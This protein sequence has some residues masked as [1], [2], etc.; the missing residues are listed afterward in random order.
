MLAVVEARPVTSPNATSVGV[1][2]VAG[3]ELCLFAGT[4]CLRVPLEDT[5]TIEPPT[6]NATLAETMTSVGTAFVIGRCNQVGFD[7]TRATIP[8]GNAK[9]AR[10]MR[11]PPKPLLA[12]V[13]RAHR[14]AAL[15][16]IQ[17]DVDGV[18]LGFGTGAPGE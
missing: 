9:S 18:H 7:V 15:P 10:T 3:I 4:A 17:V 5:P 6:S 13:M 12:A 14:I 8:V 1:G 11:N 16:T 2:V